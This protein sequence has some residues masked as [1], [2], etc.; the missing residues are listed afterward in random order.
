MNVEELSMTVNEFVYCEK[1]MLVLLFA[2][3]QCEGVGLADI[4]L[5]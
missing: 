3:C 4:V 2:E 5:C 1:L